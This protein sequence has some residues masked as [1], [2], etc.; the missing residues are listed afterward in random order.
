MYDIIPIEQIGK[1]KMKNIKRFMSVMLVLVMAQRC[2]GTA[3][4]RGGLFEMK[5][6]FSLVVM[7]I[8][9]FSFTA[10]GETTTPQT[11]ELLQSTTSSTPTTLVEDDGTVLV[12]NSNLGQFVIQIPDGDDGILEDASTSTVTGGGN[13]PG[14]LLPRSPQAGRSDYYRPFVANWVAVEQAINAMPGYGQNI[15]YFSVQSGLSSR[16]IHEWS[17]AMTDAGHRETA[18]LVIYV[19]GGKQISDAEARAEIVRG[20]PEISGFADQ[21]EV[22]RI[23]PALWT[24]MNTFISSRTGQPAA[25]A[26]TRAQVRL[27]VTPIIVNE[28]GDIAPDLDATVF[29]AADCRNVFWLIGQSALELRPIPMPTPEPAVPA[30]AAAIGNTISMGFGHALVIADDGSLWAWGG[31]WNGQL[32]DGT[33]T[34]RSSPVRVGDENDW[35]LVSAGTGKSSGIRADGS[36]WAWGASRLGGIGLNETELE[37]V[38]VGNYNDWTYV[39][40][41]SAHSFGIR[42]DGS[43]WACAY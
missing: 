33:T 22:R 32:G 6:V 11:P 5:K 40:A 41:G 10:C 1:Y 29:I 9:V 13:A 37:P 17:I 31:N 35:V 27:G 38:R 19:L 16:L 3:A 4:Y 30:V 26:D 7:L 34:N 8:I 36:L 24:V 2:K 15:D 20:F 42:A 23:D 14:A 21:I 39:H 12:F 28:Q 43:L 18:S 25:F